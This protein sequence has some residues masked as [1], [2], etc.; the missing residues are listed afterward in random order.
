MASE[1]VG[2]QHGSGLACSLFAGN[3]TFDSHGVSGTFVE[4]I[5]ILVSSVGRRG[6]FS[7]SVMSIGCYTALLRLCTY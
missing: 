4:G 7:M 6:I 1:P 3:H 5:L 2:A